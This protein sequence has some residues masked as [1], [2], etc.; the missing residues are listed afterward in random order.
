MKSSLKQS[1]DQIFVA[2]LS[3]QAH[4]SPQWIKYKQNGVNFFLLPA[5]MSWIEVTSRPRPAKW[6]TSFSALYLSY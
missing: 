4:Y 2:N 6:V 5:Q 1:N 3:S